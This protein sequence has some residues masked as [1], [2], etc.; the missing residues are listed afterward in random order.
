MP[1]D[2]LYW[3]SERS[4][5]L[6]PARFP[7]P[8]LDAM[9]SVMAVSHHSLGLLLDFLGVTV[10]PLLCSSALGLVPL[11]ALKRLD[12]D[13]RAA[14]HLLNSSFSSSQLSLPSAFLRLRDLLYFLRL[15]KALVQVISAPF[16]RVQDTSMFVPG[17][18]EMATSACF[19]LQ[20]WADTWSLA[21]IVLSAK[22]VDPHEV[23]LDLEDHLA[24]LN[25]PH[26][27]IA[28]WVAVNRG[29]CAS[30]AQVASAAALLKAGS[31]NVAFYPWNVNTDREA[32]VLLQFSVFGVA[33]V[34]VVQEAWI[35]P[36]GS[37]AG[38]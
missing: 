7:S 11:S 30:G 32:V 20:T 4:S 26:D 10:A 13:L 19:C 23:P 9:A 34:F 38:L 18:T 37:T 14:E 31:Y 29:T 16:L 22:E 8:I 5:R 28:A 17:F 3:H 6:K 33:G 25:L 27:Y 21:Q 35:D 1:H 15:S 24:Q 12:D 2:Q 36:V